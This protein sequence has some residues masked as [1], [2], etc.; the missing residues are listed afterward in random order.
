[1]GKTIMVVDDSWSIRTLLRENLESWGYEVI[2]AES[3]ADA[4]RMLDERNGDVALL[5]TDLN[6]VNVTGLELLKAISTKE[7]ADGFPKIVLTS[8]WSKEARQSA[9]ELGAKIWLGKPL[10]KELVK[11]AVDALLNPSQPE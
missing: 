8:V 7:Y 9:K 3:G 6:M 5:I 1:M 4:L 2:D 10:R 11:Q